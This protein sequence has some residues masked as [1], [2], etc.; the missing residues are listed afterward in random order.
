M[1]ES[2]KA[3]AAAPLWERAERIVRTADDLAIAYQVPSELL[4]PI[5][6]YAEALVRL[7]DT[8]PKRSFNV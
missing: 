3:S 1:A 6:E 4:A 5:Y 7:A 2:V 8:P